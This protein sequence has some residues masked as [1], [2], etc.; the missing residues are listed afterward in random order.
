M[1][2]KEMSKIEIGDYLIKDGDSYKVTRIYKTGVLTD[3]VW[4]NC[5]G[6]FRKDKFFR[7]N[8][9]LDKDITLI[10]EDWDYRG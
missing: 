8:E 10:N 2:Q 4:E 9:L 1:T 5:F 3:F 7:Y 6:K